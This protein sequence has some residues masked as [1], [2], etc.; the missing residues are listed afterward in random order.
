[1]S[2]GITPTPVGIRFMKHVMPEPNSGCWLWTGG[3]T[4]GG[5]GILRVGSLS[6]GS[7]RSAR[8]SR[9][10]YSLFVGPIDGDL[11]VCHKCDVPACVNPDHLFLGTARDNIRDMVKKGRWKKRAF[12]VYGAA[13]MHASKTECAHGHPLSGDNL[14][15]R[16]R[17]NGRPER[18]CLACYR[19][20]M[21]RRTQARKKR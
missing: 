16:V 4:R 9:L 7:R 10:A 8:A 6:D 19:A 14:Q 15:M 13:A 11:F 2:G 12:G 20:A 5:Y 3:L 18:V 21:K 17:K 1:M